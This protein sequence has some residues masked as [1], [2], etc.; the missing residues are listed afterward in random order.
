MGCGNISAAY[1]KM[2]SR[3]HGIKVAAVADAVASV[4]EMRSKEYGVPA[5]SPDALLADP[6]IDIILNLTIPGA[7]YEVGRRALEAG[8]HV[9]SEKPY[10]LNVEEGKKLAA[11]AK[12]KGLRIG[13]APDTILGGAHQY[14]RHLLDQGEVGRITSGV[15]AMMCHGHESWHPSPEFYYKVGG[16]PLFDM[17]PYY[18]S[19]LVQLLGP[20]A[21]VTG[22]TSSATL[23]RTI[24]SEPKKG[25][26]IP[27][28]TPTNIH[29]VLEFVSGAVVTL[30]TSFDVWHNEIEHMVLHGTEGAIYMP[31]PNNFFGE[32]RVA[33]PG[34][35]VAKVEQWDHAFVPDESTRHYRSSG[36]ADMAMGILEGRPHRCNGDFALHVIDIMDGILR[37]GAEKRVV[38]MTTSCDRFDIFTP[39]ESRAL[40][41][42]QE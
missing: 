33:K 29:A 19:N 1:L 6:T 41:V 18:V 28:E 21:R 35:P 32:I 36:L 7:H 16:G 4:A 9:F 42:A 39:E 37:A 23:T 38:E 40:L 12:E 25:T 27:V 8:K 13:S 15:C 34:Q 30:I 22:F 10:V 31:D 14:G 26:V 2:A 3:F 17:G 11:L 5:V 20:V 24:T